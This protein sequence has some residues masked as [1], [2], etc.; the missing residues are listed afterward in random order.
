MLKLVTASYTVCPVQHLSNV[1]VL[2]SMLLQAGVVP[3]FADPTWQLQL[4]LEP[5]KPLR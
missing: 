4:P 1:Y 3:A 2:H 5:I